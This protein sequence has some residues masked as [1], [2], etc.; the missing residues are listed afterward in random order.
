MTMRDLVG[1]ATRG[2]KNPHV[3]VCVVFSPLIRLRKR[4]RQKETNDKRSTH[5]LIEGPL[6]GVWIRL[7]WPL[8]RIACFFFPSFFFVRVCRVTGSLLLIAYLLH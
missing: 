2:E 1:R 6:S 8:L 4:V 3:K 7:D 5:F